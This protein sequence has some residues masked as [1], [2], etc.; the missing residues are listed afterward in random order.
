MQ[1]LFVGIAVRNGAD[2]SL[3]IFVEVEEEAGRFVAEAPDAFL[4]Y[5]SPEAEDQR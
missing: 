3:G 1:P 5:F 4:G 2:D